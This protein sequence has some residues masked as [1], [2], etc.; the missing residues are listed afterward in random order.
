MAASPCYHR[1]ERAKSANPPQT[2]GKRGREQGWGGENPHGK[3]LFSMREPPRVLTTAW[4]S[5]MRGGGAGQDT[6]RPIRSMELEDQWGLVKV[7]GFGFAK[8]HHVFGQGF[9]DAIQPEAVFLLVYY[10]E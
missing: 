3:P 7:C 10:I 8:F 4:G 5:R 2:G 6:A 9:G 1:P